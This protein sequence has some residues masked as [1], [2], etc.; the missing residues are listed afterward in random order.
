FTKRGSGQNRS[1]SALLLKY[2]VLESNL[3]TGK[4]PTHSQVLSVNGGVGAA[5]SYSANISHDYSGQ[6]QP[7]LFSRRVGAN[8]GITHQ[9]GP[10]MV[11][12]SVR[13]LRG[14]NGTFESGQGA[15]PLERA[16]R[17]SGE[18]RQESL[19]NVAIS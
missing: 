11:Q 3:S 8:I 5:F 15:L 6:W 9:S 10:L 17:E 16:L 14:R 7:K 19:D 2:G 4:T 13:I 18:R 12:G 1:E